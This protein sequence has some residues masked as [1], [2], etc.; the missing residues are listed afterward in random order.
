[1]Q[2]PTSF[3]LCLGATDNGAEGIWKWETTGTVLDYFN[4]SIG[5]PDNIYRDGNCLI[6]WQNDGKWGDAPCV[7]SRG[8]ETLCEVI[9]DCPS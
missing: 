9:F 3:G 6:M 2:S 5:E 1:M 4:W 8:I 7:F